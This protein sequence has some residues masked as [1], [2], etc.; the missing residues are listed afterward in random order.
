MGKQ[1][2]VNPIPD[3]DDEPQ[4]RRITIP[5][6]FEEPVTR[7]E[8]AENI[9]EWFRRNTLTADMVQLIGSVGLC[10]QQVQTRLGPNDRDP[11]GYGP[12]SEA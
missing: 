7:K 10:F 8:A 4:S 9:N 6:K 2:Y 11:N 1:I 5:F 3:P 12:R